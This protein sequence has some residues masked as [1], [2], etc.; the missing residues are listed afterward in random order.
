[1]WLHCEKL[2]AKDNV[3]VV[4]DCVYVGSG[5]MR[6]LQPVYLQRY[7]IQQLRDLSCVCVCVSVSVLFTCN[8][9]KTASVQSEVNTKEEVIAHKGTSVCVCVY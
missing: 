1:M 6:D 2:A 5:H 8:P 4:A 9:S 7:A 3:Y